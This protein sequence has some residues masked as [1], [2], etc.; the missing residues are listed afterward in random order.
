MGNDMNSLHPDH[1]KDLRKSGLSD[2]T[3]QEAGIYSVPPCEIAKKLAFNSPKIGSLLAFPYPGCEFERYKPFPPLPDRKYHQK[4]NTGTHLY[5]PEK[6]MSLFRLI[7]PPL[8]R[9]IHPPLWG[10]EFTRG[11]ASYR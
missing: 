4:A 2:Q 7:H 9:S 3:I 6:I 1:L 8:F 11:M 5:I 10:G